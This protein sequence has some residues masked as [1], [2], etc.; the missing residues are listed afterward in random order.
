MTMKKAWRNSKKTIRPMVRGVLILCFLGLCLFSCDQ[1]EIFYD[2]SREVKPREPKIPGSPTKIVAAGNSFYVSNG[3]SLYKYENSA[4]SGVSKPPGTITDVAVA[5]STLYC[6]VENKTLHRLSGSNWEPVQVS[7]PGDYTYL[8]NIYGGSG[9]LYLCASKG[10]EYTTVSVG[11]GS[12]RLSGTGDG[13]FLRGAA[14]S[15]IATTNGIYNASGTNPTAIPSSTGHP[16]MGI[17][18]IPGGIAAS[19]KDGYIIHGNGTFSVDGFGITFDRAMAIYN[20]KLLLVGVYAKGF[21]EIDLTTWRSH[22]PGEG[23][24]GDTTTAY[25]NAQYRSSLGI[26]SLT[27][28]YRANTTGPLFASTQQKGLWAY[29]EGEEGWQWNAY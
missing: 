11:G 6:I 2:I 10:N 3:K 1:H 18:A 24:Y 27:A 9:S 28:L 8:Q 21:V 19:T 25:D 23:T 16:I 26:Q 13:F 22:S 4:W 5:G 29:Q 12:F 15:Y 14:S 20:N 7:I 17:I